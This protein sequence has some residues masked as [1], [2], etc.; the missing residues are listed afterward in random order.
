MTDDILIVGGYGTVG[1][2]V[3]TE[4]AVQTSCRVVAAGR[5]SAKAEAF[6]DSVAGVHASVVDAGNP[7][8]YDEALEGADTVVVC[9]DQDEPT[10]AKACLER[11]IDYIDISPSDTLLREIERFD[12]SAREHGATAVLSVGLSPGM[13]NL[14]VADAIESLDRVERAEI[15]LLL[16]LGE[17]F[18][19]DTVKWTLEDAIETFSV[20]QNGDK[21]SVRAFLNARKTEFPGKGVRRAYRANLADQ[22]VLAR[23]TMIPSVSTRICYDSRLVTCYL[24]LLNR[25]GLYRPVVETLGVERTAWLFDR[26]PIGTNES[27]VQTEVDGVVGGQRTRITRWVR[28]T[29][30]ARA[31]GLVTA[32]LVRRL[33]SSRIPTGVHHIH[34]LFQTESFAE[35]LTASGYELGRTTEGIAER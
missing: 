1:R 27:I 16:G 28:G 15:S 4:L 20:K 23:T 14:F 7:D 19:L 25:T 12:N 22:H 26:L 2:T 3:C 30:Q 10:L 21:I 6:A 31:T 13:T 24:A 9:V 17:R 11:G 29:D 5:T 32:M 34:Q 33:I 18:G 35:R 8:T